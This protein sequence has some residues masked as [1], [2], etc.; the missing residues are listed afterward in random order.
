MQAALKKSIEQLDWRS[1]AS[2]A[3][4]LSELELA[5]GEV[6]AAV[7]DA[8]QSRRIRRPSSW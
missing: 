7:R 1:A 2:R 4:N 3:V 6:V 8:E 5:L